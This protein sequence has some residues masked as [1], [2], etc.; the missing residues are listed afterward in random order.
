MPYELNE[1]T[2]KHINELL[3]EYLTNLIIST[4]KDEFSRHRRNINEGIKA[5]IK[6]SLDKVYSFK[7]SR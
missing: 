2:L 1:K 3:A 7:P 4:T 5:Y 6:S